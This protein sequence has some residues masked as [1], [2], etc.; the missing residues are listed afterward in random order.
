MFT[1]SLWFEKTDYCRSIVN[2]RKVQ[3]TGKYR[4]DAFHNNELVY[5]GTYASLEL[6]R[7]VKEQ[8]DRGYQNNK[9]E[10]FLKQQKKDYYREKALS[11]FNVWQIFVT[12]FL[13]LLAID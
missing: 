8:G 9:M 4:V 11:L 3:N 2:Y 13:F 10:E 6:A 12:R 5:L 1:F 7:S